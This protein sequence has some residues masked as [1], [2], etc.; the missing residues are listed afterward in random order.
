MSVAQWERE[1]ITERTQEAMDELKRLSD[2][3]ATM[4]TLAISEEGGGD[5][6]DLLPRARQLKDEVSLLEEIM[7]RN[8]VQRMRGGLCSVDAGLLYGDIIVAF[9]KIT[10]HAYA[11]IKSRRQLL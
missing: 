3:A 11:I 6:G 10:D 2:A 9:V 1:A 8:H 4:V 5:E 7:H